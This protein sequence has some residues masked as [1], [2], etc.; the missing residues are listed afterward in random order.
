M[1]KQQHTQYYCDI[2]VS[3][4]VVVLEVDPSPVTLVW[5]VF[6]SIACVGM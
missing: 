2:N 1:L 6:V 3:L 5:A 4:R